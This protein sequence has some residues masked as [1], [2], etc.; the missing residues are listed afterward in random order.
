MLA[1]KQPVNIISL[2]PPQV[3]GQ[4]V[5]LGEEL[6]EASQPLSLPIYLLGA[7]RNARGLKVTD[8]LDRVYEMLNLTID[9]QPGDIDIDYKKSPA[10]AYTD[11][12]KFIVTKYRYL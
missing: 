12:A 5:D 6:A 4:P 11:V 9:C 2:V 3:D 1:L 7:I 8:P 10:E